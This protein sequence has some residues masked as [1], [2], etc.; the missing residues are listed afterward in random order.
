MVVI[1]TRKTLPGSAPG[2]SLVTQREA[3][4]TTKRIVHGLRIQNLNSICVWGRRTSLKFRIE[5]STKIYGEATKHLRD[6]N[7]SRHSDA[8]YHK[9]IGMTPL[10]LR[11]TG[12]LHKLRRKT[13]T[14]VMGSRTRGGL[15]VLLLLR[16]NIV[17]FL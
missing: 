16:L 4:S 17:S 6:G 15:F 14:S 7:Q 8:S 10:M 13:N 2:R 9:R 11:Y 12:I 5:G 1:V 3:F